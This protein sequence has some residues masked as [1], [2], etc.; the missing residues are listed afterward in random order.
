MKYEL[1]IT[2]KRVKNIIIKVRNLE[3]VE[4]VAPYFV[5]MAKIN[6]ILKLKKDWIEKRQLELLSIKE[7]EPKLINGEFIL[8]LG[9]KYILE[10]NLEIDKVFLISND[11]IVLKCNNNADFITKEKILNNFYKTQAKIIFNE[12]LARFCKVVNKQISSLKIR[13]MK[14]RWGSCNTKKAYIN[15][16]TELI[17]KPI[18]SIEAVLM[19]ELIHLYHANHSKDFYKTLLDFMPDYYDR[20]K[21]LKNNKEF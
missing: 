11:K 18:I 12:I 13:S 21:Y 5:S 14:T 20:I 15:L 1:K 2:R 8:F 16:N 10:F 3:L 9:K 19:H 4:V 6:E 7:N 17:K